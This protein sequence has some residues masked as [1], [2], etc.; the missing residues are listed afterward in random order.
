MSSC[1]SCRVPIKSARVY[2]HGIAFCSMKC[3]DD[4][5]ADPAN[6]E[7]LTASHRAAN[8]SAYV[9]CVIGAL[10]CDVRPATPAFASCDARCPLRKI[11][12]NTQ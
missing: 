12:M 10:M 8:C 11:S 4:W 7:A 9:R 1:N 5:E 6:A 3:A 2:A